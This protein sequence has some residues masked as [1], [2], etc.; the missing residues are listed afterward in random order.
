MDS[1]EY[2]SRLRISS[3]QHASIRIEHEF[4]FDVDLDSIRR[5]RREWLDETDATIVNLRQQLHE[6]APDEP[7]VVH[8]AKLRL[9]KVLYTRYHEAGGEENLDEAIALLRGLRSVI[10]SDDAL[11]RSA[12]ETLALARVDDGNR[13]DSADF[14]DLAEFYQPAFS[15]E[16]IKRWNGDSRNVS[17][18][19]VQA[20]AGVCRT[21]LR[22]ETPLDLLDRC[23]SHL[24]KLVPDNCLHPSATDA[25]VAAVLSLCLTQRCFL[26]LP[27]AK[28]MLDDAIRYG[29]LALRW[30][31]K[32]VLDYNHHL[33]LQGRRHYRRFKEFG[34]L[35]S[36]LEYAMDLYRA[37]AQITEDI[38]P[39]TRLRCDLGLA[40][41]TQYETF[42]IMDDL[43]DSAALL[44]SFTNSFPSASFNGNHGRT[45]LSRALTCRFERTGDMATLEEALELSRVSCFH[46][47][48]AGPR[49]MS[50]SFYIGLLLTKVD[51][52]RRTGRPYDESLIQEALACGREFLDLQPPNSSYGAHYIALYTVASCL[53]KL[54]EDKRHDGHLEE[55]IRLSQKALVI[56]PPGGG[57]EAEICDTLSCSLR[58]LW[59]LR[60]QANL[61]DEAI[62]YGSRGLDMTP[63]TG[64]L[65]SMMASRLADSLYARFNT[66]REYADWRSCIE[67]YS[68]AVQ[69]RYSS[70]I[71][72]LDISRRWIGAA[73]GAGDADTLM[74]AYAQGIELLPMLAYWG[75][76]A[77]ARLDALKGAPGLAINAACHALSLG[78]A[79]KA[80]E[81]LE[82]GRVVFWN[83][84][85]QLQTPFDGLP[86]DLAVPLSAISKD[87]HDGSFVDASAI[88]EHE[89]SRR[90]R[91]IDN[92]EA[93]LSKARQLP[94][95]EHLLRPHPFSYLRQVASRGPVVSLV[96]DGQKSYAIIIIFAEAAPRIKELPAVSKTRL[97]EWSQVI[98][99]ASKAPNSRDKKY[100]EDEASIDD[101]AES[102]LMLKRRAILGRRDRLQP[103]LAEIWN[104]CILP[105]MT[106][107][108]IPKVCSH[109]TQVEA[110]SRVRSRLKICPYG[111]GSGGALLAC[112]HFCLYTLP[113]FIITMIQAQNAY[114]TMRFPPLFRT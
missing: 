36:D 89:A 41:L 76:N 32:H 93:L 25:Q 27:N 109:I 87:L 10:T 18:A 12:M 50:L 88:T 8:S 111:P 65:Y 94:G 99:N 63:T 80:I 101:R 92:F 100:Y 106:A 43:D 79:E 104:D 45:L 30:I 97:V 91:T 84:M 73:K 77:K 5:L 67:L 23:I 98:R 52:H 38:Q 71:D 11:Q 17:I 69:H 56:L 48:D 57:E 37:A 20:L 68:R 2:K 72:R 66:S 26:T 108:R 96:C 61:L 42:G 40:L 6:L 19:A 24:R 113:G 39:P 103:I 4:A 112:L 44:R 75:M 16:T 114:R 64:P 47:K 85:L 107:L 90:R 53:Q 22:P 35:P 15:K 9:A 59:D 7:K 51:F 83:G 70:V 49:S 74:E 55:A 34:A 102:R 105:I 33:Y 78:H 13:N 110:G 21:P 60:Q 1:G 82:Q 95:Y 31:P 58:A 62:R 29:W 3:I 28:H 46:A 14:S 54:G 81:F 86:A